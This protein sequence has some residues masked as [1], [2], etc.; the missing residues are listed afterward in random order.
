MSSGGS[1]L[2]R[3]LHNEADQLSMFGADASP[4]E[5]DALRDEHGRL[6]PDTYRRLRARPAGKRAG[7]PLGSVNKRSEQ[8]AKLVIQEFGDPVLGGASLYAMPLDQLC[9]M[10]LVADGSAERSERLEDLAAQ[11]T[12][13]VAVLT[14]AVLLAAKAGRAEELAA[15]AGKL[16]TAAES[17][18]ELSAKSNKPGGLA[19]QALNVQLMARRFVGEYVHSK[20]AVAVDVT[21][22]TDGLLVMPGA[23]Q[24]GGEAAFVQASLNTLMKAGKIEPDQVARLEFRDGRLID[25]DG[26]IEEADFDPIDGEDS[27]VG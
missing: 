18:G 19:L 23:G 1:S 3:A 9:E 8:L 20:R 27:D 7:R 2:A 21:H 14:K 11:V 26:E 16:A 17:L 22:R 6:P 4:A 15:A 10:L 25:P 5:L 12:A 13:Q 24:A